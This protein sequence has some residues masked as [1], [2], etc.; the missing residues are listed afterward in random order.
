V[1]LRYAV[2]A[3]E[4]VEAQYAFR[5]RMAKG[6]RLFRN[7]YGLACIVALLGVNSLPSKSRF[8]AGLLFALAVAL[9][10]ER[11]ALWRLRVSANY[12]H[13]PA[14]KQSI[15][16]QIEES[17][18]CKKSAA[19]KE[20]IR[21]ANIQACHEDKNVF[22]LW[23][24]L[25]EL[26]IIP[27][28][29]F[30]PGD[31]FR[32]KQLREKEL[33][34]RSTRPNPDAMLLRFVVGWGIAAA[35]LVVL[36][37]GKLDNFLA[38]LPGSRRNT[39]PYSYQNQQS[40]KEQPATAAELRGVGTVYL[41]PFGNVKSIPLTAVTR[42]LKA[43]YGLDLH[44]LP[45]ISPPAWAWS[46]T[47]KEFVAEDLVS[48]MKIAYPRL[49]ADPEAILIGLTD[50]DMYIQALS[51]RYAFSFRDEERFAVISTARLSQSDDDGKAISSEQFQKRIM[52]V[53]IR[54]IGVLHYR[55]QPSS[56][57]QSV[58]Y[59]QID[60]SSE[61][62]E[63]GD[64][65]LESD[66]RV[67]A[68][69][70]VEEGD[71]CFIVRHYTAPERTSP[72]MGTVSGC[73]GYYKEPN[74]ETVQVDLR[75]GLLL[76]Q[77][78]DFLSSEA[79]PLELT[80]VLRT[81]DPRPRAFGIGGN[82]NLNVFLVGDKWPFTWI[83]LILEHGGRSHFRRG[84]WGF[85]YW[86]ARFVN[87]DK[88]RNQFSGSTIEWAWPGWKLRTGGITYHFPDSYGAIR[89][90]QRGPIGIERYDGAKIGLSRNTAGELL[91]ARSS[92]GSQ[93]DFGYDGNYRITQI[94]Q[95]GSG[96]FLY[97]Y[98]S[99]GHLKQVVDS[100]QGITGYDYDAVGH[101]SRISQDGK[102][103]CTLEYDSADRVRSEK[104]GDGRTYQFE[105]V[106]S[107]PGGAAGVNIYDSAGPFRRIEFFGT[108]YTLDVR[109][110]IAK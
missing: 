92:S 16:L 82:H 7:L 17:N 63:I 103:I 31:L 42:N 76:D 30:S 19:G 97:S 95:K 59:R 25:E 101:I 9:I 78:T 73:S 1:I 88:I 74:L 34:V 72:A 91:S 4:Y 47:R 66:L 24:G 104:L 13:S 77:R 38:Q 60:E 12:Q 3:R 44:A 70:H 23:M 43:L 5:T 27:K 57:F 22:V 18:L 53:L 48:A 94:T 26:L 41:V 84:N 14:L 49:A 105:Y 6:R 100:D 107:R 28:R 99:G 80:R 65:Y 86:D 39:T 90:E 58:L 110:Q 55:L 56:Q 52:K 83:D 20:E 81:Q 102:T 11:A 46:A 87:S 93:L 29:A 69:L 10:L 40:E 108:E 67:R 106:H 64:D 79:F 37:L 45:T 62:D 68:D 51:W 8:L 109:G 36:F 50:D 32:F 71:P 21:W 85:G 98:D 54:D 61:L 89:P 96:Q 2:S 33:I 35:A 15:E 75:Y